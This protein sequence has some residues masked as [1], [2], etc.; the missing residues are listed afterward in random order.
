MTGA[1]GTP[2][3]SNPHRSNPHRGDDGAVTRRALL[4]GGVGSLVVAAGSLAAVEAD[5]LPGRLWLDRELGRGE[6]DAR[7]PDVATGPLTYRT[8][9]SAARRTTVTWG[10][11]TPPGVP[12]RGLPVVLVLHGRGGDARAAFTMLGLHR[13][14][15][16]HVAAG[17]A[18]LALV[19]VD[20]GADTYYHPR[21]SGE[22]PVAMVT[23]ELLPRVAEQG[24]RTAAIGVM[25][26]SMGGYGSLLL[27]RESDAGR[28]GGLRV[29]AASAASPAL[30]ATWAASAPHAFD[31]P[32]DWR[33][34][35]DLARRPQVTTVPLQVSCGTS[36]PF[37]EQ[38]RV[39]RAAV[40]PTPR[41]RLSPGRHDG[42]YWRSLAAGQ[43]DFLARHLT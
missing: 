22:D 31:D 35:G 13:F 12:A 16:A 11:A 36:D 38:T 37:A 25:G 29:A 3:S 17:R 6:V 34:W 2:H 19:S 33:R 28:L 23:D 40:R 14:L 15:A 5:V 9:A 7:P 8:F 39:Y 18:P 42:G 30:F 21:S 1:R 32:A 20:G 4:A 41:G 10:L 27:A 43:L 24:P 26:W